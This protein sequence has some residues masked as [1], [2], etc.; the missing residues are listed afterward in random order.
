MERHGLAAS[1]R[2]INHIAQRQKGTHLIIA[3][4]HL[5]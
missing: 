4:N 5:N 1:S 3:I 2:A